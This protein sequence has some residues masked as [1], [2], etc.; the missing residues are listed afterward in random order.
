MERSRER[1]GWPRR[2]RC[3]TALVDRRSSGGM[4]RVH[5]TVVVPVREAE[6]VCDLAEQFPRRRVTT[7]VAHITV[8]TPFIPERDLT[9][10]VIESLHSIG[11]ARTRFEFALNSRGLV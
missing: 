7:G 9:T 6:S 2:S 8:A 3:E 11:Q 4:N 1:S 10:D 5:L